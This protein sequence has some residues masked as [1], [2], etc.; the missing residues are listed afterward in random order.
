MNRI[1]KTLWSLASL[2]WQAV[3]ETA[4]TAGKKS[5][6]SSTTGLTTSVAL[7]IA[8]S[9]GTAAQPPPS[10]NQL[11]VG[12]NVSQG[13]VTISQTT[14]A[15]AAS[16]TVN[17]SSQRAVINWNSFNLGQSASINFVQPN[18][19]SV[20]LNRIN[21][22]NPSQIFGRI[23]AT[24]QVFLSNANGVY[25][26]PTSS[27]DVGALVATTHSISDDNFMAG[28]YYFERNGSSGK[29][30]NEGRLSSSLGGYIALLA[31]E[32]QNAGLVVANAGTVAMASGEV[33]SL[34]VQ[35]GSL[36]GITTTPSTIA[37][38]IENKL[39]VQAP[40]GQIILSS[41]ALNKL[42]AGVIKNSGRLEASSLVSKG[43]KIFLEA[44]DI[45]LS[46]SSTIEAKGANGGG[47]V[48]VGGDWQGSGSMHQATKVKME[49]GATID[50][51]ATNK[52]DGGKVVFWSDVNNSESVTQVHGSIKAD[53][54][55]ID[56]GGGQIETSGHF[57]NVDDLQVST[58][59]FAG[60]SGQWLLDP[61]NVTITSST[62]NNSLIANTFTP[63]GTNS[64]ISASTLSTNL[65]TSSITVTTTGAG[66]DAG[67]ITVNAAITKTASSSRSTL[68]LIAA[69]DININQK[70]EST[71]TGTLP[72]LNVVL[73]AGNNISLANNAYVNTNGGNLYIGAVS[74]SDTV[75]ISGQNLTLAQGSYLNS[76]KGLM[77]VKMGGSIALPDNSAQTT[78]YAISSQYDSTYPYPISN[79][80]TNST[81]YNYTNKLTTL[82]AGG[83][84]TTTNTS[85][86]YADIYTGN[87]LSIT[88]RNI[89]SSLNPLQIT[90]SPDP[91][92]LVASSTSAT[93]SYV[94]TSKVLTVNN[95]YGN[96][97]INEIAN[98]G[99]NNQAFNTINLYLGN[100]ASST[101][102]IN[103]SGNPG[104]ETDP[105]A[106]T[107][108]IMFTTDA[109][110]TVVIPNK[111][112]NTT[113]L[114]SST[115]ISSS[116]VPA[117]GK[118]TGGQEP[119]IF[120]TS[121]SLSASKISLT[122]ASITLYAAPYYA[123]YYSGSTTRYST[124][125]QY[126]TLGT[127]FTANA[128]TSIVNTSSNYT[129]NISSYTLALSSPVIGTSANSVN[130]SK[131]N[132]LTL[133]TQDAVDSSLFIKAVDYGFTNV[134]IQNN[135][136]D[137][138]V[139]STASVL[140]YNG[141]HLNYTYGNGNS[142]YI[143]SN[144]GSYSLASGVASFTNP[145]GINVS[146][147]SRTLSLNSNLISSPS[148]IYPNGLGAGY[149]SLEANAIVMGTSGSLSIYQYAPNADGSGNGIASMVSDGTVN[150]TGPNI[151]VNNANSTSNYSLVNGA[152]VYTPIKTGISN[153]VFNPINYTTSGSTKY[154][155]TSN[156]TVTSNWGNID[157][158]V[159][160]T[161]DLSFTPSK[162]R[163]F[164]NISTT[165]NNTSTGQS[166]RVGFIGS[167][168]IIN[169]VDVNG[170]Y[171]LNNSN[172][173]LS[174]SNSHF[175]FTPTGKAVQIDSMALGT[176]NYIINAGTGSIRLNSDILTNGGN[177]SL[178]ANNLILMKSVTINSNADDLS[179]A[180]HTGASG[181]IT[182]SASKISANAEGYSLTIDS[183]SQ[184][185]TSNNISLGYGNSFDNSSVTVG[186]VSYGGKYLAGLSIKATRAAP[187]G[188][189]DGAI[190][191]YAYGNTYIKG[192]V[193]LEGNVY[194]TYG[195]S[196]N[197][198]PDGSLVN[199]GDI[200]FAGPSLSLSA[201]NN[202][203]F[204]AKSTLGN[205]GN[206][207]LYSNTAHSVLSGYTFNI[208]STTSFS[209]GTS[210][211][212]LLPGL[213]L[214][215]ANGSNTV[216]VN[217]GQ[218]NLYGN[219]NTQSYGTTSTATSG[220][221]SLTGDIRL[222]TDVT[223][224]TWQSNVT[225]YNGLFAGSITLAG[226]GVSSLTGNK[227][228]TL[229]TSTNSSYASYFSSPSTIFNHTAGAISIK[230]NPSGL[231]L[232]VVNVNANATL[233]TYAT[234][235]YGDITI[236]GVTSVGAQNY[237]GKNLTFTS[238][239]T[240]TLGAL[241]ATSYGDVLM[242]SDLSATSTITL[243]S[244]SASS[245]SVT[246]TG[247]LSTGNAAGSGLKLVG[248][249]TSYTLANA[250]NVSNLAA[251]LN[252]SGSLTFKNA[253]AMNIGTVA[254]VNG[255]S[256]LGLIDIRTTS[257]NLTLNKNIS[258]TSTSVNAVTLVAG[259]GSLA[260]TSTGG[261]IV[262]NSG[263]S[264]STGLGARVLLYTGSIAGSS[265]N[266]Q[267]PQGNFRYNS[268]VSH[269]N[270]TQAISSSQIYAIYREQ[271]MINIAANGFT[272]TYDGMP[273][274]GGNGFTYSGLVNADTSTFIGT[275]SYG[276][277]SQNAINAF[278]G[279][280]INP[281][282]TQANALGY[283]YSYTNGALIINPAHLTVT[284]NNASKT[285]GDPN[286]VLST[287]VSGFVNNETL[288]TSGVTGTGSAV[289]I[290]TAGTSAG[291]VTITAGTGTLSANNYDFSNLINGV[292][293]INKAPLT[294]TANNATKTYG[295]SNPILG[296]TISGFV[297]NENLATSGVTGSG[298]AVA[299]ATSTT[300]VGS[301][302]I[303]AGAGNLSA[304]NYQFTQFVNGTL[305]IGQRALVATDISMST[306]LYGDSL[307]PGVVNFTN[308]VGNDD[309]QA[310][311]SV[312][313]PNGSS[314]TSGFTKA[315]N[316]FQIASNVLS[317]AKAGNYTFN[318]MT[319]SSANYTVD[320]RPLTISVP[321]ATKVYDASDTIYLTAPASIVGV[322]GNDDVLLSAGNV[323]GFV[324]K[325]VGLNKAVTYIGF[326]ING[327]MDAGNYVLNVNPTSTANI[328]A[329]PILATGISANDKIYD[330]TNSASL[331]VTAATIS[332]GATISSDNKVYGLDSVQIDAS[333]ATGV[334]TNANAGT[335]KNVSISGL[336]LAGIDAGNYSVMDAS[337]ATANITP[338]ALTISGL[339][340]PA[341]RAYNGD[342]I[343]SVSG[344]ATLISAQAV[345]AGTSTDGIP[346]LGDV[347]NLIGTPSGSYNS[348][349]V[350]TANLIQFAGITT[351]NN[352][353]I[354][355]LISQN[356]SITPKALT[357]NGTTVANKVYDGTTTASLSNGSLIGVV[358]ADL[359]NVILTQS[360][361][362]ADK[363]AGTSKA[364][365]AANTIAGSEA[366]NYSLVQP[367]N[368]TA[369]ITPKALT[370]NGTTVVNK[371]YDGTTTASLSN[372]SLIG[373]VAADLGNVI[374]TQSGLFADKNA[375]TSK[376]VTAAN[377]IAGSEAGNYSL[378]QPSNLTA[379][380]I[381]ANLTLTANN[382]VKTSGQPN[383]I[384][385]TTLSGFVNNE[386]ILT[387]GI[388]GE[389]IATSTATS[390][391]GPGTADIFAGQGTLTASN[392][393]F[394][395]LV[396]GLLTINSAPPQNT[397]ATNKFS[398]QVALLATTQDKLNFKQ[399]DLRASS[400]T[401]FN[402]EPKPLVTVMT[403]LQIRALTPEQLN[404]LPSEQ[405]ANL[406]PFQLQAL[407]TY[408]LSQLKP[409]VV[410]N[411][412]PS[413]L[414]V[415]SPKQ[416]QSLPSNQADNLPAKAGTLAITILN[417]EQV[418][419]GTATVAFEQN[420]NTVS[421]KPV[422]TSIQAPLASDKLIFTDKLNTFLVVKDNG[423]M[424]EFQGSLVNNR[425]VIIASSSAAKNL[426]REE[427]NL[428]LAAAVTSLGKETRVMLSQLEGV[429]LDLR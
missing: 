1:F 281:T 137:S 349:D 78:K 146:T 428:V 294:V 354:L 215:T 296:T 387:A 64:T 267:V 422:T 101:F 73:T 219:I 226:I 196:I 183:G 419:S 148:L 378:V 59:A 98:S 143:S 229:N 409:E 217:G 7:G 155:L 408:Q 103:I 112:I 147:G 2:S 396:N 54:G 189:S 298:S 157:I 397:S 346:Y 52:G 21:D 345:G 133:T 138:R 127:S 12:G 292:L 244:N 274:I 375:G 3:P 33:I 116:Y 371:V 284:A 92:G 285:Y 367:S 414:S 47:T 307:L 405:V 180:S 222:A 344:I 190:Y 152:A 30:I 394:N 279:Y 228:L 121:L 321:G 204:N 191:D 273:F 43:G 388:S 235:S 51:S 391:S 179:N 10:M 14:T 359:G 303:T 201:T 22:G 361:L 254:S 136:L 57:L 128:S 232:N 312:I 400:S 418:K 145:T 165:T 373:V 238:N 403:G 260:N 139:A 20:T 44:D 170:T 90:G 39:A 72:Q 108:H 17:Q 368:L 318:G 63:V 424:V 258:T 87:E 264:I 243:I 356:A 240:N 272:K 218:I 374:L 295:D 310:A 38:L 126:T 299:A 256:S 413:Q 377:T 185:L 13:M 85:S 257:G 171:T 221:I 207:D 255:I 259:N 31:P 420:E 149:I 358:A 208:D 268:D 316:Y 275:V 315:G 415:M 280:T 247:I 111:G 115:T 302:L 340:A 131:G 164:N 328:T 305:T 125:M 34:Q 311:V 195:L 199:A 393:E 8:I 364:V 427:M 376:A 210:G 227:N 336:S 104:G 271:P 120:P 224:S 262:I 306:S 245:N 27:V 130:I 317:G 162:D 382:A 37:T 197:T 278:N 86:G 426:A 49:S 339:T 178:S 241:S 304:S 122:D 75:A 263:A 216:T 425:M 65:N 320:P 91:Y 26:S 117:T 142:F 140:W 309:V 404:N 288:A 134:T 135:R 330:G 6:K 153:V 74:G 151:T 94:N 213:L 198:N 384:F 351:D 385:T 300:D 332:T 9:T 399:Q 379:D 410:D 194:A 159:N 250:N 366:G 348:K 265:F 161:P 325:N 246:G 107:G 166:I 329:K 234:G 335:G 370:V 417:N 423:E 76:G 395:N 402:P 230:G 48:L 106:G 239:T 53:A 150:I 68:S 105:Y 45:A 19:Q 71:G 132:T 168:D 88:A 392:Y 333:H 372:G 156:L 5:V 341:S 163:Y 206:I 211:T 301:V 360:G 32:V 248:N 352:N 175:T 337:G 331:N 173:S 123:F 411:L 177:I 80:A 109:N 406:Q 242:N 209:G 266:L 389:A 124:S 386:T 293:T 69:H 182:I 369:D 28:K 167:T 40:D 383:P 412:S 225:T 362:F 342:T 277:T 314:S 129:S 84:I 252:A 46:S 160:K 357:V 70:V 416:L 290:A 56:G 286:P 338:K 67:D 25:F 237:S 184:N 24:G 42:Q 66:T 200:K 79:S 96:T 62:A 365:T 353:Y 169:L 154:T 192:S 429:V 398:E 15:Q 407:T 355:S 60:Q 308:K 390:N 297:N 220:K 319:S 158:S 18:T 50:V 261:D 334:F 36:A 174:D 23:N 58:Q 16:M 291:N 205:G 176:G 326:A 269:N 11:P 421:L 283:G 4:K 113:G 29:I 276:G 401:Q 77:T 322:L 118:Y 324:D 380:I 97:F 100:Q 381:K 270:F 363:N 289:T 313:I 35:G 181:A 81:L 251:N 83:N 172:L 41:V 188:T 323:T 119:S 231:G 327:G 186:G 249:N 187:A 343:A 55:A 287:T 203:I 282:I 214:N 202:F 350:L 233:N 236:N 212:V 82:Y 99:Y 253:N 95:N 347:I 89:G 110:G 223:M 61:Y 193:N 144:G 102:N 114:G 141:D 93:G